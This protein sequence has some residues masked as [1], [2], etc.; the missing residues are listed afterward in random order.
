MTREYVD[1][2]RTRIT[3]Y[4]ITKVITY[5]D[6]DKAR[7]KVSCLSMLKRKRSQFSFIHIPEFEYRLNGFELTIESDFIKGWQCTD[8]WALYQDVV[9]HSWTF[10]DPHPSNFITCKRSLKTYAVDLDSFM[11]IPDSRARKYLWYEK[12]PREAFPHV[13]FSPEGEWL[14]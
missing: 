1:D 12:W 7:H 9:N 11:C 10:S 8:V 14:G 6:D 13:R 4:S 2:N 3:S 5:L